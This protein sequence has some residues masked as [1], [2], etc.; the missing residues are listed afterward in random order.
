MGSLGDS[1]SNGLNGLTQ[2]RPIRI[3]GCSGGELY[4][5]KEKLVVLI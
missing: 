2:K 5:C 1:I 4:G 3:A